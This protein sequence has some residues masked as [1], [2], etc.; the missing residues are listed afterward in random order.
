ME[1]NDKYNEPAGDEVSRT[2]HLTSEIKQIIT[3]MTNYMQNE[4]RMDRE[5][6]E[7]RNRE[8]N[9]SSRDA[10][11]A[12]EK[13]KVKLKTQDLTQN[14]HEGFRHLNKWIEEVEMQTTSDS[15]R[16]K[17]FELTS[18]K[19]LRR[20]IKL[21]KER[22][23][24]I[25]WEQLK[26]L[27]RAQV[28]EMDPRVAVKRFMDQQMEEGDNIIA[29]AANFQD[30]YE[31][32]CK[33]TGQKVLKPG[34]NYILASKIV[35]KMN[36]RGKQLYRDDIISDPDTTIKEMSISF[37]NSQEFK[38]K[39]FQEEEDI[40]PVTGINT[41]LTGTLP[42]VAVSQPTESKTTFFST[43]LSEKRREDFQ[44]WL[45]WKCKI[46]GMENP[47]NWYTCNRTGC[48]GQATARQLPNNSWQCELTCG[49]SNW[50]HD[51]WCHCCM[52]ANPAFSP[53]QL[54]PRPATWVPQP[55]PLQ[56]WFSR[57]PVLEP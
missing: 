30:E 38:K 47:A 43:T 24:E 9:W 35:G 12:S 51:V 52:N 54:R 57:P 49:Q 17:L 29:F 50:K 19:S 13:M 31:E 37:N 48:T 21:S 7:G 11:K 56:R 5:E 1:E 25:S 15:L 27:L 18:E 2:N 45:N 55:R 8:E 41:T 6:K 39:L 4:K 20:L 34:Y 28:P 40:K 33:A 26:E 10:T 46:C 14:D 16:V 23:Q 36:W 53:D 42:Q 3:A 22:L 44:H 32:T